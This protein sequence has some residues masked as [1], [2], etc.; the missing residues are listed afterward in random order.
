MSKIG[1]ITKREYFTRVKK[2]SFIIMTILGPLLIV[3]FLSVTILISTKQEKDYKVLVLDEGGLFSNKLRNSEKY[4]LTWAP[5]G[6]Y[7]EIQ[8]LFKREKNYDLLLY[9]PSNIVKTNSMTAKCLYK[10][11]PSMSAQKHLSSII[12]EAI[13]LYRLKEAKISEDSYRSIKT[14]INL[15]II[16]IQHKE[17]KNIQK[18]AI[19]GY[20]FGFIV[21]IFIF[22]FGV[23]VMKGVIEEKTNRIIEIVVSS[24]KPFE[25]LMGKIIGIAMVG[26]TQFAG[27][28]IISMVLMFTIFSVYFPNQY[29]AS[30]QSDIAS[31]EL[32]SQ[33]NQ[34]PI[35]SNIIE[36]SEVSDFLLNDINWILMI[37]LF[38]FYFLGGYLLYGGLM[39]AIGS[40]V[41]NETDTQ[42]FMLPMSLPL[43]FAIAI[44]Q[45][46]ITNPM[47]NIAF[48]LSEIPFTSP[49]IMLVRVAMGVGDG[50]IPVWE[51]ILSMFLLIATFILTTYI[52]SKIYRIGILMYGKKASY[53]EIIKWLRYK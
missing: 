51:L 23:Q 4:K 43:V 8:E 53:K 2:K 44:S 29:N 28:V 16:D 20:F 35:S 15:D 19:V 30:T 36:F 38:I 50:G 41:D 45:V 17:N 52:A 47:S 26:L 12:N 13:E 32:V 21:Y 7:S 18:R 49:I 25:L 42:Q 10:E 22:M 6:S 1:L 14:R 3:G 24:V 39:A 5:K 27:W 37:G 33:N 46:V 34:E 31:Q 11:V 40:A 9:M 48:W